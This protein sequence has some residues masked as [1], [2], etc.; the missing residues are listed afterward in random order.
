VQA[1][2]QARLAQVE[3]S[4][5]PNVTRPFFF[6]RPGTQRSASIRVQ[7]GGSGNLSVSFRFSVRDEPDRPLR[8]DLGVETRARF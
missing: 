6:E 8:Q 3:E 4:S 5:D 1:T 7:W 2:V